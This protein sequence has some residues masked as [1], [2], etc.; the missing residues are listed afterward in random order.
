M[1]LNHKAAIEMLAAPTEEID[2]NR[3]TVCNLHALLSDNLLTSP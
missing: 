1:I 3:Y 2:F